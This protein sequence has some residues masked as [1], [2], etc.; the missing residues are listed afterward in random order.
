MKNKKINL[1]PQEFEE[2]LSLMTY[3][4]SGITKSKKGTKKVE[5]VKKKIKRQNKKH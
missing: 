4:N 3:Q 5:K 1:N 2:M